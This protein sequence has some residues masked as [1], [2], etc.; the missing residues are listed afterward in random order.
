MHLVKEQQI[1]K[2]ICRIQYYQRKVYIMSNTDIGL[3]YET[4]AFPKSIQPREQMEN[5]NIL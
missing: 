2:R 5:L 3:F 4:F 1:L